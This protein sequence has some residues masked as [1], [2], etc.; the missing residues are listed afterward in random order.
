MVE[1]KHVTKMGFLVFMY[2]VH[3]LANFTMYTNSKGLL[4]VCISA[5]WCENGM[6]PSAKIVALLKFIICHHTYKK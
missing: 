2:F 3:F 6:P 5:P 4:G 1:I